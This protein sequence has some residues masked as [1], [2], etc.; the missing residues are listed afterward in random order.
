MKPQTVLLIPDTHVSY[1]GCP[2]GGI[3]PQAESV[4]FQAIDIIKPN[5]CVLIGD[6]GEWASVSHWQ[7][8]KRKRPS[9]EYLAPTINKEVLAINTWLDKLDKSLDKVKCSNITVTEGNHE[10]WANNF[11]EEEARPEYTAKN[12]MRVKERG[13]EWHDHGTFAKIGKLYATHGG[14][15]TGLHHAYKTVV[16]LSASCVYGH[17]H[18]VEYAHAMRLGGEYAAWCVGCLCKLNKKFLNHRPTNWSHSLSIIHVESDG[19]FHVEMVDIFRG[20]GFIY[21]KRV[22]AK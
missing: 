14:H 6:I 4:L 16:G 8:K 20:V 12:L 13:Y 11:A 15:F 10:V 18:S 2:E 21:G 1:E 9:F 7:W 3:D 5:R 19:R 17:F 22:Q